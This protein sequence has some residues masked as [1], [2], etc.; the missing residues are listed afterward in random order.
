MGG[1][2]DS[3]STGG[4]STGRSFYFCWTTRSS[5]SSFMPAVC[6]VMATGP[7]VMFLCWRRVRLFRHGF[8]T[9]THVA[10]IIEGSKMADCFSETFDFLAV[11]CCSVKA[12]GRT[13]L[14]L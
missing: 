8:K 2:Y 6:I 14:P 4:I 1:S 3:C 5:A 10:G 7:S 11:V 13:L 12:K 9:R